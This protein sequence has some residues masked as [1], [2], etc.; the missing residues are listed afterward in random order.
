MM[1]KAEMPCLIF[2]FFCI[3]LPAVW[4]L[5][6]QQRVEAQFHLSSKDMLLV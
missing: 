4:G 5:Y 3:V 1:T 6:T 2:G